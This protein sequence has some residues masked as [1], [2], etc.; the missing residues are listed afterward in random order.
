MMKVD[1][2][3]NKDHI[4]HIT[5]H[6]RDNYMG[7][8]VVSIYDWEAKYYPCPADPKEGHDKMR[9]PGEPRVQTGIVRHAYKWGAPVLLLSILKELKRK[10]A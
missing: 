5:A 6:R 9:D 10:T 7:A 4:A 8:D 2:R 1:I 3:V